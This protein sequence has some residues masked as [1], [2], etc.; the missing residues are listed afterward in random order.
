MKPLYWDSTDPLDVWDNPNLRW[1]NPSYR[2]EP[3]DPGYVPW[4]PGPPAPLPRK[5]K[6]KHQRPPAMNIETQME[7]TFI[8]KLTTD[9]EKFTTRPDFGPNWTQAE[10]DARVHAAFPAV[11]ADQCALI[12][13]RYF[14]EILAADSP[15]RV[16]KLFDLLYVRPSCGG[17]A[18]TPDGFNNATDIKADFVIAFLVEVVRDVQSQISI[19]KTGQEG[20]A[21]PQIDAVIDEATGA[22]NHYTALQNVRLVGDNLNFD[23]A[24]T[25]QGVFIAP[26]AGGAWVR[27]TTYG[28]VTEKNIYV[29]IPSGTAGAQKLRVVNA[30]GHEGFSGELEG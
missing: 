3:G 24:E 17:T 28:P 20:V 30:R 9:G 7:F 25:D 12:A 16:P 5:P 15:R 26:A 8:V 13:Q 27:L 10:L 19:R 11:P 4:T 23:K 2:L 18:T 14:L 21:G 6:P 29:L 22:Q 1:G